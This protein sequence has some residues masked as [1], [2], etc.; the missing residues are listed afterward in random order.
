M[1]LEDEILDDIED[2]GTSK[3]FLD[4][5]HG[6]QICGKPIRSRYNWS[7]AVSYAGS[8][9]FFSRKSCRTCV[10]RVTGAPP[11]RVK[12]MELLVNFR[13]KRKLS[14]FSD[15]WSEQLVSEFKAELEEM[16]IPL[17][18]YGMVIYYRRLE[19]GGCKPVTLTDA[20]S[21]LILN[22]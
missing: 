21:K 12:F 4:G 22:Q 14:R 8:G 7:V 17:K 16:N 5:T 20:I 10:T 1:S 3:E 18:D 13:R 11:E 6:C 2:S 9:G 15:E 19:T